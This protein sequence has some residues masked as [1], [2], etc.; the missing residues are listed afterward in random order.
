[1]DAMA[2]FDEMVV[3]TSHILK[4]T[5]KA[6]LSSD[7]DTHDRDVAMEV[8]HAATCLL[9]NLRD[10][11]VSSHYDKPIDDVKSERDKNVIASTRFKGRG[12]NKTQS[13]IADL[14]CY[15]FEILLSTSC[16]DDCAFI[17]LFNFVHKFEGLFDILSHGLFKCADESVRCQAA[18]KVLTF[19]ELAS[20]YDKASAVALFTDVVSMFGQLKDFSST[21]SEAF[22][23]MAQLS[24]QFGADLHR[25]QLK[26]ICDLCNC[27]VCR[28]VVEESSS[29]LD[30]VLLGYVELLDATISS[31]ENFDCNKLFDI[32][33][34]HQLCEKLLYDCIFALPK[35]HESRNNEDESVGPIF[36][37]PKCK[38][39]RNR[40][41][42]FQLVLHICRVAPQ[43]R[44]SIL[45]FIN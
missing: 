32:W 13:P 37:P 19:V 40:Q 31:F 29:S 44:K 6:I 15:C 21:C 11:L 28:D 9:S 5:L 43:V 7:K 2:E 26:I 10:A 23:L 34:D 35:R 4:S 8:K 27:I 41:A 17:N 45:D 18:S 39:S 16:S 33:N 42:I 24:L 20:V 12:N 22:S 3:S 25:D 1:M 38:S 14:F 30:S 36:T